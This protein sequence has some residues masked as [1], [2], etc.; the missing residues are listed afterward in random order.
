MKSRVE[1][2]HE[3]LRRE[4]SQACSAYALQIRGTIKASKASVASEYMAVH[5]H[6]EMYIVGQC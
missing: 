4:A 3:K 1:K 2:L 6:E 5:A